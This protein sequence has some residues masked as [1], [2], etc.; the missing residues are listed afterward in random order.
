[1]PGRL[2]VV[3]GH[4]HHPLDTGWWCAASPT[5]I[6]ASA[7]LEAVDPGAWVPAL[8]PGT[9]AAALQRAGQW[10]VDAPERR[11]DAET[12]WFRT[13]FDAPVAAEPDDAMDAGSWWLC[14]DGIAS[15]AEVWLNGEVVATVPGMFSAVEVHV[16]GR[17][18]PTGNTLA[19]RCLPVD[20][21]LA[22]K[23]PRP[24]WR[25]PMVAHQQLR[26]V[27]TTMLGRTP[28][29]T[30]PA[31]PVGPWRPVRL[32]RRRGAQLADLRL[33][34]DGDGH[35]A[36]AV[37]VT[38][39]GPRP[40]EAVTLVLARDAETHRVPMHPQDGGTFAVTTQLSG[41]AR[42]WPHTHGDPAL[43]HGTLEVR[44]A[45]DGAPSLCAVVGGV[46]FR[47]I[48]VLR[49]H[50]DFAVRVN[51]VPVFCRGAVWTPLDPVGLA[52]DPA[53]LDHAFAQLRAAGMNMLRV[54]GA[55][56]PEGDAFLDR[57]DA[58]GVLLWHDLPF[59]NMDY[60]EDAAFAE[61]AA[62]EVT[63]L[64]DRLAGRPS[65]AV[66]CGNSE[67]EQQA[68]MW[69]A[70]RPLWSPALFHQRFPSLVA[71]QLPGVAYW[72]SSAHGGAF[73][74]QGD[75]G[76]TSYYG[77]GAYLRPLEDARRAAVRFATECLA[78]ANIPDSP[79]LEPLGGS[80]LRAHHP[81]W[82]A[83]VPR[84]L[85]AGWDFDDV[86]DHYVGRLFGVDPAA[87]RAT[88]H[89]HY[90]ELGRVAVGEVMAA[91]FLEWRR[92][93]SPTRGAL[94]WF[95]R[96]LWHG[97]GWGVVDADGRP[98]VPWHYLRRALA[99]LALGLT[100]EGG[101]GLAVH[102]VNDRP[103]PWRGTLALQAV[104]QGTVVTARG[105][106][107]VSVSAHGAVSFNAGEALEGFHDL[108]YA[109]RFGPP[110]HE[111][112]LARLEDAGGATVARAWHRVGHFPARRE[113]TVGLEAAW[114]HTASGAP[115]LRV[116]TQ[117]AALAVRVQVPGWTPD[118]DAFHLAPGESRLLALSPEPGA[119]APPWPNRATVRALN[120]EAVV[121]VRGSAGA[122][123]P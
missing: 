74:H 34:T 50:G 111:M 36:A 65:V 1:V 86:R 32:E 40:V 82:K 46:G 52:D 83:R 20:A 84:D 2:H 122:L 79:G 54:S 115:A 85:G 51:G 56:V 31:A 66:V 45:G 19:I 97:A 7:G 16:T 39:L 26:W 101:N 69:G 13:T 94:V 105:A 99:P 110:P 23:R 11:F 9:A 21:L 57:C 106:C 68:A 59:A 55:L 90:L 63:Q 48:D 112:V 96:D 70:L 98:K 76:T 113:P 108:S 87:V 18:R 4:D 73:P 49:E 53:A 100:D 121:V 27:R 30:P 91:T 62:A 29:W 92:A 14:L 33:R 88:D 10:Q 25:T 93:G 104:R 114:A 116:A 71:Q 72:P 77:V 58:H 123:V 64:L 102:V 42:W 78:F 67:G 103:E 38:P 81:A 60:P 24:R 22:V 5:A 75:A 15:V 118:D 119:P 44:L 6:E 17:L 109:Y 117:A 12:W 8:V 37:T 41:V 35:L 95:L 47:T 43:Y 3:S 89:E 120:S 80:A 107:A 28:G 61:A